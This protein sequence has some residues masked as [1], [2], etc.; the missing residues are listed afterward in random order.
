MTHQPD[1]SSSLVGA[2]E[3]AEAWRADNEIHVTAWQKA[4]A[5]RDAALAD[6]GELAAITALV[7]DRAEVGTYA[8]V[9]ALEAERNRLRADRDSWRRVAEGLQSSLSTLQAEND[10]LAK[11]LWAMT[12]SNS[13]HFKRLSTLVAGVQQLEQWCDERRNAPTIT[14]LGMFKERLT[15]LRIA[16]TGGEP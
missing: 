2:R 11:E 7:S 5:E 4:E 8:K 10:R 1:P 16:A 14:T 9:E 15:A 6:A 12:D 3:R 13:A